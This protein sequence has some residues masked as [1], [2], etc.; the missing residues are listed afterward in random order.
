MIFSCSVAICSSWTMTWTAS[1]RL[2]TAARTGVNTT[3]YAYDPQGRRTTADRTGQTRRFLVGPTAGTDLEVIHAVTDGTT[4][5]GAIKALYVHAGD[6]P[7]LRFTVNAATG[8][9]EN[10]VYYLEDAQ[11]SVVAQVTGGGTVTRFRYDGF[12]VARAPSGYTD[13]AATGAFPAGAGGDFRFHGHWLEADT[14]FYHMRARD[15]DPASGRFL[16]RDP[17][18]GAVTE[19][20]SY[21]PYAFANANPHLFSDPTGE[22]TIIEINFTSSM[23]NGLQGLRAAAVHRARQHASQKIGEFGM[24]Q[25]FNLLKGFM[26]VNESDL[27]HLLGKNPNYR[28]EGFRFASFARDFLCEQIGLPDS[29]WF[30]SQ[31]SRDGDIVSNGLN[32]S[33]KGSLRPLIGPVPRPDFVISPSAPFDFGERRHAKAWLVGEIKLST[34]GVMRSYIRPKT[35]RGQLQAI[36][37]YSRKHTIP[38]VFVIGTLLRNPRHENIIKTVLTGEAAKEGVVGLVIS[39]Q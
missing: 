3:T 9:L 18:E 6:Q 1:G 15:Y 24:N 25:F 30:E 14:G 11:G 36:L 4:G 34:Q 32:C 20:E 17:V 35:Q 23:Q 10:P 19:P 37:K 29:I 5:P 33:T 38:R 21:H 31:I 13:P 12:G 7:I 8:A 27:G 26:P 28:Y 22:F 39:F 2:K 16:S